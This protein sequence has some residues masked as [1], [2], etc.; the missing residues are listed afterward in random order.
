MKGFK[1][2]ALVLLALLTIVGCTRVAPGYEGIM[3]HTLGENKGEMEPVSVGRYWVGPRKELHTFPIFNQNYVWTRDKNEGS[4][5]DESFSFP[6]DGLEVGLD[7]GIE[8]SLDKN[9]II[10]IF[11][12]YRRGVDELTDVV[13]RK[14]VRDAINE[15]AGEYDM[16][17]L[18]EEGAS[19]LI[20]DAFIIA[21]DHFATQGIIIHSLSLVSAPRYPAT[22]VRAIEAK[23]EAT[24]RAV[25]RENELREAEAEA[26]KQV[27]EA[28][29]IGDSLVVAATARAEAMLI[30]ARAEAESNTLRTR[31][32]TTAVLQKEW[33]DKWD[34][35]L[36]EVAT[37]NAMM[38]QL[39]Q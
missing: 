33:I 10:N 15:L 17:R 18:V 36:P 35:V 1:L 16:D 12:T 38:F 20:N 14:V 31:S 2:M 29:G 23:I 9:E 5:N 28:T 13:I 34:G 19:V 21:R 24:Q 11:T 6:I 37:D 32:L 8:Y 39:S 27:A 26:A 3:V 22:V 7:V 4:E 25:Q 30:E